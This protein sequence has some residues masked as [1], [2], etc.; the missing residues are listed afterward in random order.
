MTRTNGGNG[1]LTGGNVEIWTL[2]NPTPGVN[3]TI[4]ITIAPTSA[5]YLQACVWTGVDQTGGATSFP[6]S[7][8][9]AGVAST[10]I[11][12]ATGNIVIGGGTNGSSNAGI[13]G[14]TLF[15]DQTSGTLVN[16]WSSSV[17]GAASVTIGQ[18][19]ANNSISAIDI[20]ASSGGG[21]GVTCGGGMLARGAGVC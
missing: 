6:H 19:N 5:V 16:A 2:I 3:K 1:A 14:T 11:A 17:A 8:N 4:S 13:L 18:T 12:S 20:Q 9:P 15:N 10:T 7:I 21:G